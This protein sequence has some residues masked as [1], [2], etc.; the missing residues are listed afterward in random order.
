MDN[1]PHD[2]FISD[3]NDVVQGSSFGDNPG[4]SSFRLDD[5]QLDPASFAFLSPT[6]HSPSNIYSNSDMPGKSQVLCN[7]AKA[8]QPRQLDTQTLTSNRSLQHYRRH[9]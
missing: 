5:L 1:T 6:Q 2:N 8:D 7:Y 9:L 4:L 3:F